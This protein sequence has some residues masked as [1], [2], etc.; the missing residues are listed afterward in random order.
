MGTLEQAEFSPLGVNLFGEPIEQKEDGLHG[1][2]TYPP[3]TV[4]N[5]ASGGF[6]PVTGRPMGLWRKRKD[7]WLK[8]G[9]QSEVGRD[10]KSY[11]VHDWAEDHDA[12]APADGGGTSIFDPVLCE[13][14][15]RWFAPRNGTVVDPFAGGSVRGIVAGMLWLHYHGIDLRAEQVDANRQQA[16]DIKPNRTPTWHIGDAIDLLPTMP[17][18]DLIFTC[19]PYHDLEVY[20]DKPNDLSNM[21]WGG[22]LSAYRDIV[23][24]AVDQLHDDRFAVF[25][26]GDVRDKDGNYRNLPGETIKAF[27]DVGCHLYN[28][29]VLVTP[30]GTLPVRTGKQFRASRKMGK[31]HQNVLVFVKG[32]GRRA[33]QWIGDPR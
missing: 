20:S 26:V 17:K 32:D 16:I 24:R 5:T 30:A 1:E 33:A 22:F 27:L 6:D 7:H 31:Q 28:E 13:L 12:G 14:V 25:V 8:L 11:N 19:P 3:F 4:L 10:A 21:T 9:I 18:A 23:G 2:F 15:Y 29:A